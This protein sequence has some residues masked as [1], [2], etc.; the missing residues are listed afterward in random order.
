MVSILSLWMPILVSAV[1][2]FF[3]SWVIHMLLPYHR[4]DLEGLKEEEGVR[5]AL[6]KHN[7]P[8]GD[9]FVPYGGSPKAMSDPAF[10]EKMKQ[11][12]VVVMTVMK[13]GPPAMGASLVQ[14]F[15]YCIVVGVLAAYVAGVA[16]PPGAHYLKV[17]QLAGC[18][19]FIAYSAAMAQNSIWYSRKWSSTLKSMFDGLVY[20]LLTAGVFG[21]LWPGI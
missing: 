7:I 8:P 17:F 3:A 11:G 2:V 16:L 6:G 19:A 20:G 5:Q 14:W 21:W 9:Y 4:S 18:T 10:I 1:V 12:P 15:I 13:N